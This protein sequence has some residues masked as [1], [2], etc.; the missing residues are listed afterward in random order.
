MSFSL[1]ILEVFKQGGLKRTYPTVLIV[2]ELLQ[3]FF[4]DLNNS[5]LEACLFCGY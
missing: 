3:S 2:G 1:K 4:L 5:F